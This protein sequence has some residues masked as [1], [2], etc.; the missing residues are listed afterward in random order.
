MCG[1]GV[2][3]QP[4]ELDHRADQRVD[5][6]LAAGLDVLQHRGLVLAHLLGAGDA[7]VERHAER[8]RRACGPPPAPRSSSPRPAR[9]SAGT[10]RCRPA[11][12]AP[13]ADRVEREVA[14]QLEPDLGAD[15]LQHRR[16]EPGA[17]R[18]RRRCACTRSLIEPSS[19][20]SGKRSPSMW[21]T[22]PGATSSEAGIDDAADHA[23]R[24]DARRPARRSG[25]RSAPACLP[26]RRRARGS[27]RTGCRSASSRSAVAGRRASARRARPR[28]PGAPS[29]P[30]SRCP[31]RRPR[32][33]RW[34]PARRA[35]RARC[36]RA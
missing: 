29:S 15:V 33:S 36:R 32:H 2:C 13:G 20:P 19:S 23:P 9:A 27:T 22:T 26:A 14:P 24:R 11:W 18:T 30:G 7:L 5:L 17:C 8:R 6:R 16:L 12:R 31:A 34:S 3:G 21:R 1:V 10:G 25:R 4:A 35:R 28:P